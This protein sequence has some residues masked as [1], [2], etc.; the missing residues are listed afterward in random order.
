[1]NTIRTQ[2]LTGSAI[3]PHLEAL[4]ALRIEVF[5]EFPYLYEGDPDYEQ[6]YLSAYA[7]SNRSAVI[8]AFDGQQLV[9]AATCIVLAEEPD[10]VRQPLVAAGYDPARVLYLGESVLRQAYRGRG[11]GHTFFDEREAFGRQRDCAWAAFC[12]VERPEH[13]PLRPAGYRSLHGFWQKRGYTRHPEW[14]AHMH[15]Q[16]RGQAHQTRKALTFWLRDLRADD[17]G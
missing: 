10:E 7:D 8:G 5:Y 3:W 13:H 17:R 2:V 4:A 11:L 16:D 14:Q 15:W 6:G 9:G 12:A 1:M